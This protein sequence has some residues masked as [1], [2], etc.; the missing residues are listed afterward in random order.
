MKKSPKVKI[1]RLAFERRLPLSEKTCPQCGKTF[2]GVKKA[3]YC[4]K[5]CSNKVS[6]ARHAAQYRQ[7]RRETYRQQKEAEAG[8]K[9]LS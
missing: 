9:N 2:M 3:I 8:Q 7:T 1:V 4:S 6:Y 5:L